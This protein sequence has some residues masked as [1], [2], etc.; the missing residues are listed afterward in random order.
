MQPFNALNQAIN[1]SIQEPQNLFID[2]L[3]LPPPNT[4]IE[5]HVERLIHLILSQAILAEASDI[6]IEPM[7]DQ[8]IIRY[9]IHGNLKII[10]TLHPDWHQPLTTRFKLLA[11]CHL[12]TSRLPQEGRFQTQTH[13]HQI[14][15]VR[16]ATIPS[17]WG[18]AMTLRIFKKETDHYTINELGFKIDDLNWF[19]EQLEKCNGLFLITGPTGCG[20]STT[21]Y[22]ALQFLAE[23][24]RKIITIE[25]P[26]ERSIPGISQIQINTS[27]GLTFQ[28][29]LK[30]LLR[31]APNVIM[32][33]EIRDQKTAEIVVQAAL[34]GHLVLSTVHTYNTASCILRL[35]NLGIK[36]HILSQIL[37]GIMS[38]RLLSE[39]CPSCTFKK[40]QE[41]SCPICKGNKYYNRKAFFECLKISPKLRQHFTQLPTLN[42]IQNLALKEGLITL[43]E[44][45]P[46]QLKNS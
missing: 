13:H 34:T 15:D 30:A 36:P 7:E 45:T 14:L 18:D 11:N 31:Q 29:A 26:V 40:L 12:A 28:A 35:L 5:T 21:L 19:K 41:I 37:I 24:N 42:S 3:N 32:I 39:N 2:E 16:L 8:T 6:H 46:F 38:Q 1:L 9:R 25:D 17:I 23:K 43:P 22:A 33:G 20:K 10:Y 4:K 27:M 44:E